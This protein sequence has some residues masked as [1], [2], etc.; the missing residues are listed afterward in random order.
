MS[1][2]DKRH[3]RLYLGSQENWQSEEKSSSLPHFNLSCET[4]LHKKPFVSF[5]FPYLLCQFTVREWLLI[6]TVKEQ[7]QSNLRYVY[8]FLIYKNLPPY[9]Y[10]DGLQCQQFHRVESNWTVFEAG[11]LTSFSTLSS[12]DPVHRWNHPVWLQTKKSELAACGWITQ[13]LSNRLQG[14]VFSFQRWRSVHLGARSKKEND[15]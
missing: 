11:V 9:L 12:C 5:F 7:G 8:S 10:G 2:R 15:V 3:L 14:F 1:N 4:S 6:A 13:I